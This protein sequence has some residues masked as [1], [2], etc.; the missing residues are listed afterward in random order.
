MSIS[1]ENVTLWCTLIPS[2]GKDNE[3]SGS[4]SLAEYMI[5]VSLTFQQLRVSL[6][7][8]AKKVN[9]LEDQCLEYQVI[10]GQIERNGMPMVAFHLLER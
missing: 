1:T 9:D 10:E 3:V 5:E 4:Y 2:P 8:L 7:E 6:I